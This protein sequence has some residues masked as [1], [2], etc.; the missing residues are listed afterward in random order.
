MSI[1]EKAKDEKPGTDRKSCF[2]CRKCTYIGKCNYICKTTNDTVISDLR[3][4]KD[5]YSCEG[6]DFERL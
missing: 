4:T 2:L 1:D 3:P 5:Y 6:K